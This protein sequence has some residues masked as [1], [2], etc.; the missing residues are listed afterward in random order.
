MDMKEIN[1][2]EFYKFLSHYSALPW[3][4]FKK[5][6]PR[7]NLKKRYANYALKNRRRFFFTLKHAVKQFSGP[8]LRILDL[9]A[10]PG[11][12]LRI[13]K[14][15]FPDYQI[16]LFGA[17]LCVPAEF[18]KTMKEKFNINIFSVNLDPL[19]EQLR[20]KNY[21]SQL[22]FENESL[23][24]ISSLEIIEHLI[25]PAHMLKE[26]LRVLKPGGKL[27][28]TTPNVTRIGS[29][30]KL[31]AGRSNL[32]RV[33]SLNYRDESD[34]WRPHVWEYTMREL[35]GLMRECGYQ[36]RDKVFIDYLDK[37]FDV[38]QRK[39][40]FIDLCKEPFFC[41]PRFRDGILVVAEKP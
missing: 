15:Y 10:F 27:L 25:S 2:K 35:T 21:P 9:G 40:R 1:K 34:E 7:F 26:S 5:E 30:F 14:E 33:A 4:E 16:E 12:W 23:D 22:P 39:Q 24:F 20:N 3:E 18:A 8:K 6:D 17:G 13:L 32:E 11:T 29:I 36:V 31:L 19:N 37:F 41:F 38:R 28:I